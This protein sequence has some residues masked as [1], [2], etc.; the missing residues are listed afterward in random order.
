MLKYKGV[1]SDVVSSS[2][3][4][5]QK[6]RNIEV[7]PDSINIIWEKVQGGGYGEEEWGRKEVFKNIFE[8][9]G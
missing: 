2:T 3:D 9:D 5:E 4:A 1:G 6:N 8:P 7:L